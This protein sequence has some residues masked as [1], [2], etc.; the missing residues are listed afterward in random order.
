LDL[1]LHHRR[2]DRETEK[3]AATPGGIAKHFGKPERF[4]RGVGEKNGTRHPAGTDT[5]AKQQYEDRKRRGY[6]SAFH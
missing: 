6:G 5:A 1:A 3:I 4:F 2:I